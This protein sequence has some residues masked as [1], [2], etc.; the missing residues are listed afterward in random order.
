M[1]LFSSKIANPVSGGTTWDEFVAKT[2]SAMNKTEEET[3]TA[4]TEEQP[5]KQEEETQEEDEKTA[6]KIIKEDGEEEVNVNNEGTPEMTN[7][8]YEKDITKHRESEAE[9]TE[10]VKEAE[11]EETTEK[12]AETKEEET[13]KTEDEEPAKEEAKST[14]ASMQDSFRKIASLGRREKLMTLAALAA[15]KNNPIEYCEAMV[16]IK[17]ADMTDEERRWFADYM[18]II[19]PQKFV[20]ELVAKR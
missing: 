4:E 13:E 6:A 3:K 15:D 19:Y 16:G 1:R 12:Q 18:S 20:E 5:Q 8:D 17:L 10:E 11:T 14:K 2:L 9:S 7:D